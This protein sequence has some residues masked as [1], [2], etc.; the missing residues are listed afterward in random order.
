MN[1]DKSRIIISATDSIKE[2]EFLIQRLFE[3]GFA[4]VTDDGI[5]FDLSKH[6]SYGKLTKIDF[7][8]FK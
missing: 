3:K 8:K 2:M 5:Y 4:Y 7:S 6:K 1:I